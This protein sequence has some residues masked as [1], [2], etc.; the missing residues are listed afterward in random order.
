MCYFNNMWI[1]EEEKTV[2][3]Y[4]T[5]QLSVSEYSVK[6]LSSVIIAESYCVYL[7]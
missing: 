4:I 6:Q 7:L 3:G 5:D 1:H 2:L